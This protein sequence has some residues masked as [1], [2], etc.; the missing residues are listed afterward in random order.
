MKALKILL[1]S[2]F[3]VIAA[4]A[5]TSKNTLPTE[6]GVGYSW[7][8]EA[9]SWMAKDFVTGGYGLIDGFKFEYNMADSW[10]IKVDNPSNGLDGQCNDFVIIMDTGKTIAREEGYVGPIVTV[11]ANF[12]CEKWDEVR[13]SLLK[14]T[15][16]KN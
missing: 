5:L 13:K 3:I 12:P 4:C 9:P 6:P 1:L 14:L 8:E 7:W 11:L 2:L 15:E 10:G 16:A